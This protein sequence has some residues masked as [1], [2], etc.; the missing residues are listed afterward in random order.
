MAYLIRRAI[1]TLPLLVVVSLITFLLMHAAPG[2]PF[3]Q[4][5]GRRLNPIELSQLEKAYGLDKPIWQQYLLY[6]WGAVRL[7]FGPS[8]AYQSQS[9]GDLLREHFPFSA[10]L[11]LQAILVATSVGIPLGAIAA[12]KHNSIIDYAIVTAATVG[13]AI[14][15][16][17]LS[18]YLVIFF[19]STLHMV[20]I[21]PTIEDYQT[22]LKPWILPTL[23]LAT[24]VASIL[25]RYTRSAIVE[26]MHQDYVRTG[27]AKGLSE[28]LVFTRHV[29]RNAILPVWTIT[30]PLAVG[31]ITG[32][33]IV[34]RMFMMPGIGTYFIDAVTGR[35]YSMIMGTTLFYTV[36]ITIFN[37]VIDLTYVLID[38]RIDTSK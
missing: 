32:S 17:I 26:E 35:D 22:Q 8:F 18:L 12:F 11:G 6:I 5:R 13:I 15:S 34:E 19:A 7:D 4:I 25:A 28:G 29:L 3:D 20:S 21:I 16:F 27:R 1:T 37:L 14:P 9:V 33:V 38:P 30:G 31:L 36:I 23:A 2:G 10:R 24:P